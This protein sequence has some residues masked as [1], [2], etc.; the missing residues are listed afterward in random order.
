MRKKY[1]GR[2]CG[3][4]SDEAPSLGHAEQEVEEQNLA[5]EMGE[6]CRQLEES[7]RQGGPQSNRT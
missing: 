3:E 5:E 6:A 2:V 7:P 4:E 1:L